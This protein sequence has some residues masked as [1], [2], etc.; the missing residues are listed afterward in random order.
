MENLSNINSMKNIYLLIFAVLVLFG[1]EKPQSPINIDLPPAFKD[2]LYFKEGS[3][4][5]YR[6]ILTGKEDSVWI[7]TSYI[8]K[9][10]YQERRSNITECEDKMYVFQKSTFNNILL[11]YVSVYG[12]KVSLFEKSD[13]SSTDYLVMS[14]GDVNNSTRKS[15]DTIYN[16]YSL[17]NISYEN[18]IGYN[19]ETT[20]RTSH[21]LAKNVG[22]IRWRGYVDFYGFIQT[23]CDLQLVRYKIVQ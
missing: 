16:N 13:T 14:I 2:W 8:N 20:D 19:L 18:V 23:P 21:W 10:C 17:Q 1:C 12:D 9:E 7:D 5:I 11:K 4:W 6:D 22:L 15:L 3:Y